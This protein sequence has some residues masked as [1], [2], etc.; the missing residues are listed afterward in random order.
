MIHSKVA[1]TRQVCFIDFTVLV[2]EV[3]DA[4]LA[5]ASNLAYPFTFAPV[6]E[7]YQVGSTLRN[8]LAYVEVPS[9]GSVASAVR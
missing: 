8:Y 2:I 3:L 1:N 6:P 9:K 5:N 7:A 4:A